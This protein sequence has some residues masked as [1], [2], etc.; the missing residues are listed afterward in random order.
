[1]GQ[2]SFV[3]PRPGAAIN[4]GELIKE[5]E[6]NSPLIYSLRPGLTGLAQVVLI[7]Y[8]HNPVLKAQK[9]FEY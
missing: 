4:E 5:R 8:R 2:M 1:M 6:K 9:D 3:V 7:E